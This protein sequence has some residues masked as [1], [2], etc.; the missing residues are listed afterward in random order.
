M[1]ILLLMW[2][3]PNKPLLDFC[4]QANRLQTVLPNTKNADISR[5]PGVQLACG[6]T[7]KQEVETAFLQWKTTDRLKNRKLLNLLVWD[8]LE[9][10]GL[11]EKRRF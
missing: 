10:W 5:Q 11:E 2:K 7:D 8:S 4:Y 3:Q 9:N 6:Q 1:Y